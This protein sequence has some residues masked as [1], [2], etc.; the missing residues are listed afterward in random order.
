MNENWRRAVCEKICWAAGHEKPQTVGERGESD[1]GGA[2]EYEGGTAM[3]RV[4]F[5][6][7]A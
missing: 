5:Y 1:Y 3:G 2:A 7:A 4:R 6:S